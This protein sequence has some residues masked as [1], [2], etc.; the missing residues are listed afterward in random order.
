MLLSPMHSYPSSSF[1]PSTAHA[2][3]PLKSS[4]LSTSTPDHVQW[5]PSPSPNV[6]PSAYL[7]PSP[8]GSSLPSFPYPHLQHQHSYD[9]HLSTPKR[10]RTDSESTTFETIDNTYY[11]HAEMQPPALPQSSSKKSRA[12]DYIAS[13]PVTKSLVSTMGSL[14]GPNPSVSTSSRSLGTGTSSSATASAS[15]LSSN[16]NL[17]VHMRRQLSGGQLDPFLGGDHD[18]MDIEPADSRPRSMSF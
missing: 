10:S 12:N 7:T 1:G 13:R 14:V 11:Q 4:S 17:R 6:T 3:P 16:P 9:S 5:L 2:S 8:A 18:E 15:N